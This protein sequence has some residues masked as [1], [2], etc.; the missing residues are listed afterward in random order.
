VFDKAIEFINRF[1]DWAKPFEI[2]MAYEGGVMTRFGKFQ[3]TLTPG[4]YLKVPFVDYALTTH[5][6]IT[7]LQLRPQTLTTK[8]G[9]QVVIGAIVKYQIKDPKPFLLD[10][11]DSTDV[12][13]DVTLG[14]IKRVVNALSFEDLVHTDVEALVLEAVRKECNQYGFRIHKVTFTDMGKIRTLRLMTTGSAQTP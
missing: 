4:L 6:T 12:L 8:D 13:N 3:K 2:L 7:T 5:T 11:W 9:Q 10:I 14:A 1:W